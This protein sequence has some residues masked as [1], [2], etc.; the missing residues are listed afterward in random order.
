[1]VRLT[2]NQRACT[3]MLYGYIHLEHGDVSLAHQAFEQAVL[4]DPHSPSIHVAIANTSR[5][6]GDLLAAQHHMNVA[7]Q[8]SLLISGD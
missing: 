4:S 6:M 5:A 8:L 3:L 2:P 7:R 1:M